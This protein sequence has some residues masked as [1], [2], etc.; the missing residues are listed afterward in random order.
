MGYKYF[1][2][3]NSLWL[4]VSRGCLGRRLAGKSR[5][6]TSA[7]LATVRT[8]DQI[9]K[10]HCTQISLRVGEMGVQYALGDYPRVSSYNVVHDVGQ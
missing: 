1:P 8:N 4:T 6:T 9:L 5:A 2:E 10:V 3:D 7:H